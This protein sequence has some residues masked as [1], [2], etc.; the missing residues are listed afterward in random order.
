M[1]EETLCKAPAVAET[2]AAQTSRSN[3]KK[4]LLAE[5]RLIRYRTVKREYLA[6]LAPPVL[7]L[8]AKEGHVSD[9][10]LTWI[11]EQLSLTGPTPTPTGTPEEST[12]EA[13]E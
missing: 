6:T 10:D 8:L 3:L 1:T 12:R 2:A 4:A 13:S 7:D 5:T 9:E 11:S